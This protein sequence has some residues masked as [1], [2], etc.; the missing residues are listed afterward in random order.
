MTNLAQS[1]VWFTDRDEDQAL[2]LRYTGDILFDETSDFQRVRVIDTYRYGKALLIDEMFM[3]TEQDEFHYHEMIVHPGMLAYPDIKH[4]LVIG[5]GDG[6]TVRELIKHPQIETITM[7][8]IDQTVVE[9]SRQHLPHIAQALNHPK[10]N[11]IIGDGIT[12]VA[13]GED[14]TYDLVIIDGSDPVGPSKGLF[15]AEF[16]G[17]CDRILKPKGLLITQAESPSFHRET[18]VELN[19][20]LKG[21]FGPSQVKIL[22]FPIPTYPSGLW[23]FQVAVKGGIDLVNPDRAIV[24]T[25]TAKEKLQYYNY[26][27][28]QAAF[29]L[30]N[31]VKTMVKE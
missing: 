15:S 16:Y 21:I 26:E 30:P 14:Q 19:Q 8:E 20:C 24:E 1:P 28:H 12:Y 6:G 31:Y 5:G 22:L 27:I 7:V 25:F 11:L 4:V 3:C 18:F 17:H 9:A 2:S 23:S 10:L 13:Q 29:A